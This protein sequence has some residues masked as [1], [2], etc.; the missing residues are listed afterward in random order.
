MINFQYSPLMLRRVQKILR[1]AETHGPPKARVF[2]YCT[3][4]VG[5]THNYLS[6]IGKKFLH[7]SARVIECLGLEVWIKDPETGE[8]EKLELEKPWHINP[9]I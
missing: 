8:M 1:E 6:R 5:L 4:V 7:P 9:R 2:E 3:E